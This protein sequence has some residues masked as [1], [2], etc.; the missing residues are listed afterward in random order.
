M[1][2]IIV[3]TPIPMRMS[4]STQQISQIAS[5]S[6]LNL[7]RFLFALCSLL[8]SVGIIVSESHVL[9]FFHDIFRSVAILTG[10]SVVV[11]SSLVYLAAWL[12][13]WR[14]PNSED[15][16]P[17]SLDSLPPA[18]AQPRYAS[19]YASFVKSIVG[20]A[21]TTTAVILAALHSLPM[22]RNDIQEKGFIELWTC[23]SDSRGRNLQG[24]EV[25]LPP[26]LAKLCGDAETSYILMYVV[27]VL[28]AFMLSTA[29]V[30]YVKARRANKTISERS[31][32]RSVASAP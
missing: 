23:A 5:M 11:L 20:L 15:L 26:D 18:Y 1:T 31:S 16:S 6:H 17:D 22:M 32:E 2:P 29:V 30:G 12:S 24:E 21:G 10:A 7:M 13:F 8:I 27:L 9:H 4:P 3:P 14:P 25:S 28:E 19:H